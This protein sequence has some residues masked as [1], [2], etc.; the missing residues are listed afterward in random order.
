MSTTEHDSP[1]VYRRI[2]LALLGLTAATVA[3]AYL[4]LGALNT[5]AALAIAGVKA[6]LV[7]LFFMHVRES[8]AFTW[9]VIGS[10]LL[11]FLLL[12]AFTLSDVFTR[13]LLG[14]VRPL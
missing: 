9:V 1:D 3:V 7:L 12:V 8:S 13:G 4:D 11:F 2:F 5:V 10:G 6:T 14:L